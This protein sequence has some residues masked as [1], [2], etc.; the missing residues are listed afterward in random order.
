M[1]IQ[2]KTLGNFHAFTCIL[3]SRGKSRAGSQIFLFSPDPSSLFPNRITLSWQVYSTIELFTGQTDKSFQDQAANSPCDYKAS[4]KVVYV[5]EETMDCNYAETVGASI[6]PEKD[7]HSPVIF[8]SDSEPEDAAENGLISNEF[9]V[10][11]EHCAKS[12]E[13]D[14]IAKSDNYLLARI[15]KYLTG[16]PPPPKHTICQQDCNDFIAHM[17]QNRECFLVDPF[18]KEDERFTKSKVEKVGQS[19]T[20]GRSS[21]HRAKTS[22]RNLTTAFDACDRTSISTTI[23]S[24]DNF[25]NEKPK[26]PIRTSSFGLD[27]I[28]L[29]DGQTSIASSSDIRV[30]TDNGKRVTFKVSGE[31]PTPFFSTIS[32]EDVQNV[33]WPLAFKHKTH[34]IQ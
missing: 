33:G 26:I 18:S 24:G 2:Y 22:L 29:S 3:Y 15:H 10:A 25:E 31:E 12:P 27:E 19:C 30:N 23:T 34:G 14:P 4:D 13:D 6:V 32:V 17:R 16:V 21:D 8:Q 11:L 5:N 1:E 20:N 7:E 28:S 9:L